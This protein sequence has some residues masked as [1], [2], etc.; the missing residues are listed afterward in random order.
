MASFAKVAP[1][2]TVTY[3]VKEPADF[4]AEN[5][6]DRGLAGTEFDFYFGVGPRAAAL[7]SCWSP[8]HFKRAWRSCGGKRLGNW[9]A[10]SGRSV[11]ETRSHR[12]ARAHSAL[13]VWLYGDQ[14]LLQLEP[15]RSASDDRVA[16]EHACGRPPHSCG[17]RNAGAWRRLGGTASRGGTR[18][19]RKWKTFVDHR[20]AR[21]CGEFCAR[22]DRSR[23]SGGA[24]E[25]LRFLR[26]LAS[27]FK[28]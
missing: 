17:G 10:R 8:Q 3:G 26:K 2:R 13:R 16:D 4:R 6:Q 15:T 27:L 22:R 23:A 24:G 25:I 28:N 5:I 19:G 14:R 12:N 1:G 7:A 11:S 9:R 18:G 20:R 21:R